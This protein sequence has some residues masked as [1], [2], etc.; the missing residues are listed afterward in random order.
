VLSQLEG[1]IGRVEG[2]IDEFTKL[3][4]H[5]QD[6]ITAGREWFRSAR[7]IRDCRGPFEDAANSTGKRVD[8]DLSGSETGAR[9]QYYSAD[10]PIHSY[11]WCATPWR[12]ASSKALTASPPGKPP[13]GN[14]Q[15]ARL[16]P[17]QS[18]LHR[19][20]R[21]RRWNQLRARKTKRDR[22]RAGFRRD[23]GPANGA[24]SSG[25]C[26]F[27]R[28]FQ[29]LP[30]NKTE[31]AGRGVGLDV[32]RANLNA[33]NGEIEIDERQRQ[34]HEV[35][36]QGAPHA[37]HFS[38][39]VCALR[40]DETSRCHWRSSRKIRRLRADEIEDV[41]GKIAHQGARR[42]LPKSFVWITIWACRR[43]SQSMG[44]SGWWWQNAGN[45]EDRP[46]GGKKFSA[47]TK[48]LSR[49]W[50][51]YLRRVKLFPGTTIAPDG[52]LILLI[53][54][55]R[56]VATEPSER[57]PLQA[58]ASAARI[59]APGSMAIARGSIPSEAIDRVE[60]E[61]RDRGG[62]RLHQR[63]QI[64][65]QDAG[66]ERLPREAC[67]GWPGGRRT[68]DAA[69]LPS[70][71]YRPGNAAHDGVRIDGAIAPKTPRPGEFP[72]WW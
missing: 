16:S 64:R 26:S 55:N 51:E 63:A 19:G 43:W 58:S 57:R 36:A 54:L 31:L 5:L 32:V 7:C 69:R 47:R 45:R 22:A 21:R 50:G 20:G 10:F 27:I 44:I 18:H 13:A 52:S 42:L 62:G 11:T 48:S 72:S 15:F 33:L 17:R 60:Q 12:T 34:G 29:P 28:G 30:F 35:Y 37:D 49:T 65:R 68:G 3:A 71:H 1:F 6:E 40:H 4:H 2:D 53:D 23:R 8:M 70:G 66:E 61:T 25:R 56:M 9:Q 38:G 67:G 24:R 14:I 59:F 39:S 41:G 46:R